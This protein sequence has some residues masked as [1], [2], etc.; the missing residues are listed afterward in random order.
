MVNLTDFKISQEQYQ[1]EALDFE[2]NLG[3]LLQSTRN[4]V[5]VQVEG[6]TAIVYTRKS[7]DQNSSYVIVASAGKNPESL[8]EKTAKELVAESGRD[9]IVKNV[10]EDL[11]SRLKAISFEDYTEEESW[12]NYSEYDDNTF[13]QQIVSTKEVG[14][15]RGPKYS[16]L[17]EELS[18]FSREYSI[19]LETY[20]NESDFDEILEKWAIQ[21]EE[22]D[23]LNREET[24]RSHLMFKEKSL[25]FP[26]YIVR[27][28]N[29]RE[30]IGFMSFSEIS[31]NCLGFN[32][33][34]NDFS[35]RN[36]YRFMMHQGIKI[37]NKLGYQYVNLQGS[38]D[39]NQYR[40]KRRF[41]ANIE[42]NKKHLVYRRTPL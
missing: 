2:Y 31:K 37:A 28:D 34:I 24:K 41:K 27:E 14:E 39:L 7:L 40:S 11:E 29:S 22:R 5:F 33:L 1:P 17:R 36:L 18:R 8:I 10:G 9:V 13:P 6:D 26:Q 23:S 15:L 4:G 20:C 30:V 16:S 19:S 38:E 32:A 25:K 3:Y 42:I 35:Y 21:M 12:D